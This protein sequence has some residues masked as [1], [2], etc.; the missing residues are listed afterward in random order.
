MD[1][2]ETMREIRRLEGFESL[3][4]IALTANAMKGDRERC[5]E[6]G[7]SDYVAKPVEVD[8]LLGMLRLWLYRKEV[9]ASADDAAAPGSKD[10]AAPGSNGR[11][12]L[13]PD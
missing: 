10:S 9:A 3:P 2:Y 6:A 7:A 11:T 12:A 1:G 8:R 4:I 13:S 5:L